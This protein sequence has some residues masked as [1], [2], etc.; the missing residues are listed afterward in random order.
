MLYNA[1]SDAKMEIKV[2]TIDGRKAL[3]QSFDISA[4][5]GRVQVPTLDLAPGVYLYTVSYKYATFEDREKAKKII[6][7]K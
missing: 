7:K 4:G 2:F 3:D 6:I 5:T 1:V